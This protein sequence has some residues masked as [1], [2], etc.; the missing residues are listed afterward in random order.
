MFDKSA[1]HYLRPLGAIL[2]D[3]IVDDVAN[4]YDMTRKRRN[5][6][7]NNKCFFEIF[8]FLRYWYTHHLFLA[9][10]QKNVSHFL[11]SID[12]KIVLVCRRG[13]DKRILRVIF[14]SLWDLSHNLSV[15]QFKV[16]PYHHSFVGKNDKNS[17]FYCYIL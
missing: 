13:S 7:Y 3:F 2:I 12:L 14:Y 10:L 5:F 16:D 6:L 4:I 11:L 17:F 15:I 8:L 1:L 9:V